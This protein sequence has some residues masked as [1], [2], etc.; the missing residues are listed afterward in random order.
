M[1]YSIGDANFIF[2]ILISHVII[3]KYIIFNV[4]NKSEIAQEAI[5]VDLQRNEVFRQLPYCMSA[6]ETVEEYLSET[7]PHAI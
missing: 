3:F 1:S 7:L 2:F 6:V 5:K 4:V